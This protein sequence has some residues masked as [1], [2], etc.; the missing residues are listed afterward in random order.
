MTHS[1]SRD[2][3]SDRALARARALAEGLFTDSA[4]D[5]DS[6]EI[7]ESHW[8]ALREAGLLGCLRY[9]DA[10]LVQEVGELFASTCLATAF[11]WGQH[12]GA[13]LRVASG[14]KDVRDQW[15]P[16]LMA[17]DAMGGVCY[18]GLPSHGASLHATSS[19]SYLELS[20][21]APFVT[22]WPWLEVLVAWAFEPST[23]QV[24]CLAL[25]RPAETLSDWVSAERLKLVAATASATYKL[26]IDQLR[27]PRDRVL[28]SFPAQ[29]ARQVPI[30]SSQF[31]ST[32]GLGVLRAIDR[33]L[34]CQQIAWESTVDELR[35][36]IAYAAHAQDRDAMNRARGRLLYTVMGTAEILFRT[37]GS[38]AA[39]FSNTAGRLFR[40][41]AFIQTVATTGA[42]RSYANGLR[43]QLV[44]ARGS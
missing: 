34:N 27:V 26:T 44:V 9:G 25:E 43:D 12:Q 16:R 41:A 1:E 10:A 22:G 35:D 29:T 4:S 28:S 36:E 33:E 32:L 31:T 38:R 14:H 37:V 15:L 7:P 19:D 24:H 2:L 40:E 23:G 21:V 11:V 6:S 39:V 30:S 17:G 18:A 13:T 3:E 20:G 8:T 42:E 5:V